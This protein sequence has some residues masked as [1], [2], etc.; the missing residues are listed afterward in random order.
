MT[1]PPFLAEGRKRSKEALAPVGEEVTAGVGPLGV[2]S[3]EV[4]AEVTLAD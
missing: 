3:E 1:T 4:V 2:G